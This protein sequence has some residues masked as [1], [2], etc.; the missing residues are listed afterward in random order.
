MDWRG[1]RALHARR[2]GIFAGLLEIF[3]IFALWTSY[4][5]SRLLASDDMSSAMHRAREIVKLERYVRLDWE[6]PIN[7]FFVD[8][9]GL[10]LFGSYWYSAAHYIVTPAVLLWVYLSHRSQYVTLRRALLVATVLALGLYLMLPT[11]PPR[12]V[13]GFVDV[14]NLHASQG[15]WGAD[16][17]A[18]RGLGQFTNELAAFP[19]LHAGWSLW[20][21]IAIHE[22]TRNRVL[23]TLGWTHAA[24]TAVVI[25]GTGNHW[26][27]DVIVGWI[28]VLVGCVAVAPFTPIVE[29]RPASPASRR[30]HAPAPLR[31]VLPAADGALPRAAE[32]GASS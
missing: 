29:T 12:F 26:M 24:L 10:G 28:V 2:S 1:L 8:H 31:P 6:G 4:T 7:R 17:S 30:T 5:L 20:V 27:F 9:D 16:A 13:G 11:A 32:P 18:P 21:A 3:L 23:R 14:L 15:W 25:I 22:V 19:S